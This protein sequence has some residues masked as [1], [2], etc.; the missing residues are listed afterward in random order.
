M[1]D[2]AIARVKAETA[3]WEYMKNLPDTMRNFSLRRLLIQNEDTYNLY[4]YENV[5]LHR[6]VTAYYH[7]ETDEYKVRLHIGSYEFCLE[8]CITSSL[9]DFEQIL[10][11][12]F[13]GILRNMTEFDANKIERMIKKTNLFQWDFA[14]SLP[15]QIGDFELFIRPSQPLRITNGS[16]VVIDYEC[17]SLQSNFAVYYNIFRDEFFSDARIAGTPDINYEF[18]SQTLEELQEKLEHH[19]KTRLQAIRDSAKKEI[20]A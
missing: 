1:K 11:T 5:S 14:A 16:Y 17:F 7:A 3:D 4:V 12:R 15:E 19:L 10:R 9:E 6:S 13:D 18:D 8:E 2:E 20:A